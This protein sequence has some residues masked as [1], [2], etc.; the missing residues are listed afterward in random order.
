MTPERFLE[1]L[2]PSYVKEEVLVFVCCQSVPVARFARL[3]QWQAVWLQRIV[4]I[5]PGSSTYI[6]A[7]K[8]LP[9]CMTNWYKMNVIEFSI[10]MTWPENKI[11]QRNSLA[12]ARYISL[13][14]PCRIAMVSTFCETETS[15]RVM[16]SVCGFK[17]RSIHVNTVKKKSICQSIGWHLYIYLFGHVCL[18]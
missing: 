1:F 14:Q 17:L 5:P 2:Q 18:N 9:F 13:R 15:I 11:W 7:M 6:T 8:K 3:S 12:L 4:D 16:V 10:F